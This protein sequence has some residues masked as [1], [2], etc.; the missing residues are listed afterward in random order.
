[1]ISGAGDRTCTDEQLI[2]NQRGREIHGAQAPSH[3]RISPEF[4]DSR[5]PAD[6]GV[7]SRPSTIRPPI[8]AALS[9][10]AALAEN[11]HA[12]QVEMPRGLQHMAVVCIDL[13]KA[14]LLGTGQV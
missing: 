2:T 3:V 1:M 13:L 10:S 4:L 5:D 6:P 11:V 12:G 8:S 7:F 9:I 14:L